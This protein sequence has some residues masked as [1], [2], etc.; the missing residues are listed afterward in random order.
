MVNI[1][2]YSHYGEWVF[3][4]E[5]L[6][7][8]HQEYCLCYRCGKFKPNTPENCDYAEQNFRACKI[9]SMT[10]PVW[11]CKWFEFPD[12]AQEPNYDSVEL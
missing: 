1:I 8:K 4:D 12:F 9:N 6:K 2:G 10:M 3:V 11:E 7:G 5:K